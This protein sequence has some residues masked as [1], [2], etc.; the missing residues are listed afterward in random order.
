MFYSC[1]LLSLRQTGI[2]VLCALA[3]A[4]CVLPG[5]AEVVES[6]L[7]QKELVEEELTAQLAQAQEEL[8][9][10]RN[11]AAGLRAQL[12]ENRQ[13]ALSP[14]QA[15][16]FYRAEAIKFN[17][18]L[19][20]GQDRDGQPGDDALSVMLMPVDGHG[21]LVKLAGDVE[22]ELFDMTLPADQ[23]RLGTWKFNIGEVR[24]HW[25][26]GVLAAG[27]LF[28]VDWQSAPVSPDLMLHARMT[29]PDGRQFD[30]TT[31]V[32]V[33]AM[34][35][36]TEISQVSHAAPRRLGPQKAGSKNSGAR[37]VPTAGTARVRSPAASASPTQSPPDVPAPRI[38]PSPAPGHAEIPL[39]TSDNYTDDTIPRVR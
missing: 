7:R 38:R 2:A 23:Q 5:S 15:D 34:A 10:A 29:V 39:Q 9:V 35:K 27:Y 11:D 18:L 13:V 8:K 17:M 28:Q 24:E 6:E 20:S 25:Y 19:T 33:A 22:M 12:S 21:E 1:Q 16:V 4:G 3:L 32:K 26:K 37:V 30:T 31:Q 36:P 14:E